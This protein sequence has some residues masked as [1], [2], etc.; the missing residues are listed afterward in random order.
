MIIHYCRYLST[1]KNIYLF[2]NAYIKWIYKS[3]YNLQ[4]F[5]IFY[6]NINKYTLKTEGLFGIPVF[7]IL[8]KE[9]LKWLVMC[10]LCI[11]YY[12]IIK[13]LQLPMLLF[14]LLIIC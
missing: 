12:K 7:S 2:Y 10:L 14:N 9:L 5:N 3:Y 1:L 4:I 11:V 13:N 8:Q 6:L